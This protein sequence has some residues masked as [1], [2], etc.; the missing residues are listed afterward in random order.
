MILTAGIVNAQNLSSVMPLDSLSEVSI[1][2]DE[3]SYAGATLSYTDPNAESAIRDSL[4]IPEFNEDA[5]NYTLGKEDIIEILVLRHPEVSG[6]HIINNEGKIQ[7]EFIGDIKVEGFKKDTI[8]A[9]SHYSTVI[10]IT[11][12]DEWYI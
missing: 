9:I 11:F 2:D 6:E 1:S 8:R 7:Y 3:E 10:Y 12:Y 4:G 5:S